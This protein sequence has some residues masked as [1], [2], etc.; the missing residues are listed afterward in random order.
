MF[1]IAPHCQ[2]MAQLGSKDSSRNLH[3]NCTIDF[4]SSII[5]AL[6]IFQTF[7]VTKKLDKCRPV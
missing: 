5:N 2:I 7:D 6:C 3:T 1:T 4:F